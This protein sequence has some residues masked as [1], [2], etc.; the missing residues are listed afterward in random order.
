MP[1]PAVSPTNWQRTAIIAHFVTATSVEIVE[2]LSFQDR[3]LTILNHDKNF[4]SRAKE[5]ERESTASDYT[6]HSDFHGQWNKPYLKRFAVERDTPHRPSVDTDVI[7][8]LRT[9]ARTERPGMPVEKLD[10]D[11]NLGIVLDAA[12]R[13]YKTLQCEIREERVEVAE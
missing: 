10:F 8:K 1:A 6:T 11:D 9:K 2:G 5:N 4:V 13:Y 7:D 3:L 12:Q